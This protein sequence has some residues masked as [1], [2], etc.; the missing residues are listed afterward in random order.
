M[1][2]EFAKEVVAAVRRWKSEKG[3]SLN[4]PLSSVEIITSIS[5]AKKASSDIKAAIAADE[6]AIVEEDPTLHQEPLSLRPNHAAIGPRFRKATGEVLAR[7]A[8]ETPEEVAEAL[9][10]GGWTVE[11]SDGSEATLTGDD[12][13]IEYG[14]VSRGQAVDALS[15]ADSVVVI[16]P[17]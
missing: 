15:V 14:W 12:V 3:M 6:L 5:D 7:L 9:K 4:R 11:L 13:E 10:A 1:P 2:G 17:D 16:R 8:E